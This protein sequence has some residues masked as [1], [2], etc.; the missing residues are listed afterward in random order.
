MDNRPI[1]ND[2]FQRAMAANLRALSGRPEVEVRFKGRT[3]KL[4]QS[5]IAELP[6]PPE[7]LTKNCEQTGVCRGL[8]DRLAARL[9]YHD[10]K[11]HTN[12]APSGNKESTIFDTLESA[13]C[14]LLCMQDMPGV[15][16]NIQACL[17]QE[18]ALKCLNK[19]T[20]NAPVHEALNLLVRERLGNAPC[21]AAAASMVDIWRPILESRMGD[22]IDT[23]GNFLANQAGYA[24]QALE[25]IADLPDITDPRKKSADPGTDHANQAD[26]SQPPNNDDTDNASDADDQDVSSDT[27]H[28]DTDGQR[29]PPSMAN[30]SDQSGDNQSDTGSGM[31]HSL[32]GDIDGDQEE[33]RA[34]ATPL[35]S[36]LAAARIN[37]DPA[38]YPDYHMYTTKYDRVI[39]AEDMA[40]R[41]ERRRL[42]QKL[43]AVTGDI[44][45][46]IAP[47][48]ARLQ[49]LLMAQQQN[50]WAFDQEVGI[51]D[52]ARLARTAARP[53][54]P[55]IYKRKEFS[56]FPDTA[57]SLL[58]DNSGSMRGMPIALAA[59]AADVLAKALE[60]CGISVEILGFTTAA[61]KGG[62]AYQDWLRSGKPD[63]PGRLNELRHLVYKSFDQ[64]V[65]KASYNLGLMLKDGVLKENIDGE[66]LQWAHRRLIRRNAD[67]RILCVISD[68]APVDDA[69]LSA[70]GRKFLDHHLR[71]V[72]DDI[73][74]GSPVE[75]TAIG[76]GH[77]VSRYYD[78]AITLSGPDKL[79]NALIDKM[80]NLFTPSHSR[81]KQQKATAV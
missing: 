25:L 39:R 54:H 55:N 40:D 32:P 14:D 20:D 41:V 73:Q 13:R 21:P 79:G 47:L 8:A 50:Q 29:Q 19:Q 70:N 46:I 31:A 16:R 59:M 12:Y 77:D 45:T 22:K 48:A 3:P 69:T 27:E 35:S 17:E 53:F 24:E 65:R 28:D 43:D 64:P 4:N 67:R 63:D 80:V 5:D 75:L 1:D 37:Q 51:L 9:K 81:F 30:A 52:P 58:I 2:Q 66:A 36:D 10:A 71:V 6:K 42:R 26:N 56:D 61:W 49:R 23:M 78:D 7:R 76:I 34:T 11:I 15:A 38:K 60:R 74:S 33:E 57:V 44:R 62:R 68:G 72:I 18:C